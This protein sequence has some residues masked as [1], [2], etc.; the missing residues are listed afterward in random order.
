MVQRRSASGSAPRGDH[1]AGQ[2]GP[3]A[4]RNSGSAISER[5][6]RAPAA[7]PRASGR[8]GGLARR[9]REAATAPAPEP[10]GS[11]AGRPKK[12]LM[13]SINSGARCCNSSAAA[14]RD[15][16]LQP[17]SRAERRRPAHRGP[18]GA[19]DR[20]PFRLE[21]HQNAAAALADDRRRRAARRR[22]RR[23]AIP[24]PRSLLRPPGRL[25]CRGHFARSRCRHCRFAPIRS[26]LPASRPTRPL[27][28]PGTTATAA[29]AVA[30]AAG[31]AARPLPRLAQRDHAAAD[32]GGDGRP[33]F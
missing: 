26:P 17:P 25:G 13:R 32:D 24:G 10:A 14:R 20:R 15:A 28:S 12:T 19:D 27:C 1:R 21:P 31:R 4:A 30:G 5:R 16:Q 3:S 22:R 6:R 7:S 2:A 11:R 23:R 8:G 9:R 29:P 18:V 33:L